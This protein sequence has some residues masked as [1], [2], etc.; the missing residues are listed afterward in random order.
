M[1][2]QKQDLA[3]LVALQEQDSLVDSISASIARVPED[4]AALRA[5]IEGEKG[6]L[7]AIREKAKQIQLKKKEKELEMAQKEEAAKKHALELNQVKTNEAFKALQTQIDQAK[8]AA[9]E[10]ET[11]ILMLMDDAEA[12]VRE[13]KAE[14]A[15]LKQ[16]EARIEEQV[17]VLEARKAELQRKLEEVQAKRGVIG[18]EV[19]AD[20]ISQ[21]DQI[22]K[23]RQGVALA[24]VA[25]NMCGVCHI[26]LRPQSVVNLA[27]GALVTCDSCQRILYQTAAEAKAA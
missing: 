9:G 24:K 4:I 8:A 6:A 7:N 11:Q 10:L 20:L 12:A 27:K 16:V 17:K 25:G 15:K 19:P 22:R 13:E 18:A 23:R 1:P 3:K 21:Y 14:T 26:T 2:I 5:E